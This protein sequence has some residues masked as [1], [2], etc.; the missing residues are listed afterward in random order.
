MQIK[1]F[2]EIYNV[3]RREVDYWS[4]IGLVH[5]RV[6]EN[7]YRDYDDKAG[8]EVRMIL[9]ARMLNCPGSLESK[10]Q[11][12]YGI[13]DDIQWSIVLD[14]LRNAHDNFTKNYNTAFNA[15]IEKLNGG[16]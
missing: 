1:D 16:D 12:L 15:T 7:G 2:C 11:K 6:L 10:V 3:S 5:P 4:R 13:E 8:E 9:V 14:K